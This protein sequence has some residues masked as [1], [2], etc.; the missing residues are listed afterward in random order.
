VGYDYIVQVEPEMLEAME[1]GELPPIEA[2]LPPEVTPVRRVRIVVGKGELPKKLRP[3]VG[4]TTMRPAIDSDSAATLLA[5]TGPAGV[6]GRTPTGF[7]NAPAGATSNSAATP[8]TQ[9]GATVPPPGTSYQAFGYTNPPAG[10]STNG[11]TA[12]AG[13]TWSNGQ[14]AGAN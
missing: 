6:Y 13:S 10:S 1:R 4:R 14:P 2:N 7:Q 3:P 8:A 12:G 5:Q 9:P 11:A